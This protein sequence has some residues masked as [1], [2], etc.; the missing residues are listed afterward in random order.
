MPDRYKKILM[1][2]LYAALMLA[3][4]LLQTVVFGRVRYFGAKLSL[5]PVALACVCMH[6]ELEPAG[7]FGLLTGLIWYACGA[8]GAGLSILTFTAVAL[9]VSWLC[10]QYLRSQLAAA[11]ILS[12]AALLVTQGA[13]ALIRLYLGTPG[14]T[15]LRVLLIGCGLSLI[16]CPP[17]YLLTRRISRIYR[18]QKI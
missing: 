5:L 4:A 2:A 6:A 18:P 17:V 7:L 14:Q 8:D 10:R 16:A 12:A 3:A 11:L 15:G 13:L 9:G 1:W